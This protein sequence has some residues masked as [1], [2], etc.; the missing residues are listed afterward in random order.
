MPK[1]RLTV[2]FVPP[3]LAAPAAL[4]GSVYLG[5][6][7]VHSGGP[8]L[9]LAVA[10]APGYWYLDLYGVVEPFGIL[11]LV[12]AQFVYWMWIVFAANALTTKLRSKA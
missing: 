1:W 11:A 4:I 9:W 10:L 6:L 12:A 2:F 8:G 7:F 5:L 3:A